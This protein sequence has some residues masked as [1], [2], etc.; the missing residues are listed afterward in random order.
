MLGEIMEDINN[1]L[2][3]LEKVSPFKF[4]NLTK[5]I[6]IITSIF[7]AIFLVLIAAASMANIPSHVNIYYKTLLLFCTIEIILIINEIG[8][9]F[10]KEYDERWI[11]VVDKDGS[12]WPANYSY[13][14]ENKFNIRKMTKDE[15]N[16]L[17]ESWDKNH[18]KKSP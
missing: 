5:T 18:P 13:A 4:S 12:F 17:K 8:K 11:M 6:M 9:Y 2:E 10:K 16:R 3:K 1:Y 7:I 15:K 14:K